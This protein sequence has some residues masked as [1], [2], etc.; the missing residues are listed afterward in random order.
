MVSVSEPTAVA[1]RKLALV[2]GASG[3][4]GGA[5]ASLLAGEGWDLALTY[6]SRRE[7]VEEAARNAEALG[8]CASIHQVELSDSGAVEALVTE[9]RE[10]W[11]H[12]DTVIY[13]AGPY[14]PQQWISEI[15]ADQVSEFLNT[16]SMSCWNL[17]HACLVPL[18]ESRGS[19]VAVSTTAVRRYLKKD[20]LSVIPKAAVEALVRAVACEEGRSGIRANAVAVGAI[21][22][23]MMERLRDEGFVTDE[24]LEVGKRAI[25]L[26]RLGRASEIAEVAVFLASERASFVTGQTVTVDGGFAL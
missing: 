6:R 13:A 15:S 1:G 17:I 5:T 7:R 9:V 10:R 22:D 20:V 24:W 3:G 26:G 16:D 25:P 21:E 8:A 12:I 11:G 4:V 14:I 23:G 19:I 18:R 2:A